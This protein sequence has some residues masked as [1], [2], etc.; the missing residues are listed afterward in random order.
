MRIVILTETF[1]KHMSYLGSMLPK[2]L[3]RCGAEVHV[4]S[5]G[6]QPYYYLQD[7]KQTY[8]Q[9]H[10]AGAVQGGAELYDGYT[11]HTM[12]HCKLLGYVY[13]KHQLAKL[14][15]L[16]P[17]IVYSLSAIGWLPLLAAIG[18]NAIGYKLFTG[19]HTTASTFP[20]ARSSAPLWSKERLKCFILRYLPGRFIS[21]M[22]EKCHGPTSDCAEIAWRFFGVQKKKVEVMHLG[23]DTEVFY[24]I[25]TDATAQER[26]YTRD[27]LGF[28]D[29]EVVCI[30][31][32]KMTEVKNAVILAEAVEVLRSEGYGYRALFIG[33]GVQK[34]L[35][36]SYP[37]SVVLDFMPYQGLGIY[38]RAS[39]IGVWPTNEST[40]MLD[41]AACGI[42]LVVSDGIEYR[43]HVDG[44]GMVF[45]MNDLEHLVT[46]LKSLYDADT[47]KRLGRA[48]AQKMAERF[49]WHLVAS[50]RLEEYRQAVLQK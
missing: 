17:D 3:A 38:Y 4:L 28:R 20:L 16:S 50:R 24:P 44:N 34:E 1:A 23:V 10:D 35:I 45:R 15:E 27:K 22:T 47:R 46:T 33:D 8:A 2:Y 41:A 48:G 36:Q 21:L 49:S 6:L 42:P 29:D 43:E 25:A 19:S 30:Y 32:G 9:F 18:R 13:M 37:S 5:L 12:P 39:D 14:R 40:S 11:I 26:R 31:T 7:F